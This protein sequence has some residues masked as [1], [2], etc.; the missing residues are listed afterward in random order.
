MPAN[1]SH[2]LSVLGQGAG[3]TVELTVG[4][5][6]VATIDAFLCG[7]ILSRSRL[8]IL[9]FVVRVYVEGWRGS[10][11]LV[12]LFWVSLAAPTLIGFK[13]VPLWA[14]ILVIGLNIGAYGS[15]IVRGALNAVP[16]E[17]REGAVALSLGPWQQLRKV[18]LPQAVVE[19]IPP[20]NTLFIQ[21]IQA[22]A[23]AS[24]IN[25][26]DITYQ[27][28]QILEPIASQGQFTLILTIM[29]VMYLILSL[30]LTGIMRLAELAA[31]RWAGRPPRPVPL[32]LWARPAAPSAGVG[33]PS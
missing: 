7:I 1:F 5:I 22:T 26:S 3:V 32:R 31:A 6:I 16:R 25:V 11:E 20:F 10:S 28:K 19:M 30:I 21:L 29:L 17:Q 24:L 33:G 18:L 15:E 23:L 4:G 12:Q 9:R 14:G 27:G 2:F 13:L 8:R